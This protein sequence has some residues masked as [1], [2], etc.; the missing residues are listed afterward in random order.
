[1]LLEQ[2]TDA[3]ATIVA[4]QTPLRFKFI[5]DHPITPPPM[6]RLARTGALFAT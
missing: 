5:G 2:A 3:A 4:N 1:L 6:D